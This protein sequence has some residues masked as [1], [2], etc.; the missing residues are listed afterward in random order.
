MVPLFFST[1]G[2]ERTIQRVG[3]KTNEKTYLNSLGFSSGSKVSVITITRG[4]AVVKIKDSRIA[5]SGEMAM[6]IMVG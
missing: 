4:N 2:E 1:P 5:I 3:G 6:K